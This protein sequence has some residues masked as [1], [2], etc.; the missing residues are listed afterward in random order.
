MNQ[1]NVPARTKKFVIWSTIIGLAIALV[2][3]PAAQATP[4]NGYLDV[5][6]NSNGSGGFL[7]GFNQRPRAMALQPNGKLIV[8]GMF[9]SYNGTTANG[10][11]RLNVDG[12]LD[13]TFV[14]GTGFTNV[15]VNANVIEDVLVATDGSIYV[16]GGMI[17]YNGQPV[18]GLVKL[19]T[20]GALDTT[21]EANLPDI[22]GM[23]F[24]IEEQSDGEIVFSGTFDTIG[25]TA[26]GAI[27]KVNSAGQLNSTFNTNVGAG[28]D[29]ADNLVTT[30]V[31]AMAI[32]ANGDIVLGGNFDK[33]NGSTI[34]SGIARL[35]PN[36]SDLTN[37]IT[38]TF[39]STAGSGF[40]DKVKRLIRDSTGKLILVGG[41]STYQ[42]VT[43]SA[44]RIIRLNS[45]GSRDNGFVVGTGVTIQPQDIALADG[46]KVF[47]ASLSRTYNGTSVPSGTFKL[48]NDGT[49]DTSFTAGITSSDF[50]DTILQTSNGD[51][52]IAGG[53][54]T[55]SGI[56]IGRIAHLTNA[57][58]ITP[59]TQNISSAV[60]QNISTSS[61]TTTGLSGSVTY[62]VSP[63]LPSGL[64]LN[65]ATGVISGSSNS[66]LS[67][68]AY[69][70]T[71]SNGSASATASVT[72]TIAA[73]GSGGSGTSELANTGAKSH[74][75]ITL[76]GLMFLLTGISVYSGSIAVKR[77][78]TN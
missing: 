10:I 38:S 27:A 20:L 65:T 23:V 18:S 5:S 77:R 59:S 30:A 54:T 35:A 72:I 39:N 29:N 13:T 52:Y 11:A 21:F 25:G 7:A 76:I 33:L 51:V 67:A 2:G 70:V 68:T 22:N 19:S 62:S 47:V 14:T 50:A 4:S 69:T 32:Q 42:G 60:G 36:G 41:F 40:N 34:A 58:V 12:S 6:Y 55:Y 73:Q 64:S 43:G 9:T 17:S 56:S 57:P 3:A 46:D 37:T 63:S 15:A 8:V 53:F 48:N 1:N 28:F 61:M 24:A 75:P 74:L 78:S 49:L 26:R 66:P 44:P 45:D 16:G 71:A 31:L